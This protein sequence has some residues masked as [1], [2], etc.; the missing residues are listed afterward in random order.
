MKIN[1]TPKL[2][3]EGISIWADIF[4]DKA[5]GCIILTAKPISFRVT[6]L[7]AVDQSSCPENGPLLTLSTKEAKM[8]AKQILEL[9]EGQENGK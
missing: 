3:K 8:F 1:V 9:L 6:Q 4:S 5:E 2:G 7:Y